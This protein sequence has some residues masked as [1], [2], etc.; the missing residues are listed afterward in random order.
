MKKSL[1]LVLLLHFGCDSQ[2]EG[3]PFEPE[4]ALETLQVEE[5]FQV[6]LFA[7]EP[8]ISDPVALDFDE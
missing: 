1:F 8:L 2:P 5:G 4:K 7:A 3:P 6:E